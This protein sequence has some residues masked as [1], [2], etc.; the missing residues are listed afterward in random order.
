MIT[1]RVSL[2]VLQAGALRTIAEREDVRSAAEEFAGRPAV[3]RCPS[4]ASWSRCCG[5][6]TTVTSRRECARAAG[7]RAGGIRSDRRLAGGG[8]VHRAD[9]DRHPGRRRRAGRRAYGRRV[10]QEALTNVH[11]H[12]PGAH[13][14]VSIRYETAGI[15]VTV[16][17]TAAARPPDVDLGA[18]GTGLLALRSNASNSWARR[19]RAEP[20]DTGGFVVDA[21]SPIATPVTTDRTHPTH[22]DLHEGGRMIRTLLVDDERMVCAH[23]RTIL[24]AP[25]TSRSSARRTTAPRHWSRWSDTARRGPCSDLHMPGVDGLSALRRMVRLDTPPRVV[26]LTTI[27]TTTRVARAAHRRGRF[28]L[29][30]TRPE[31]LVALAAGGRGRQHGVVA[32]PPP[33]I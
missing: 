33:A 14:E 11:K 10:V 23:L 21:L 30:D 8:R 2:M 5:T 27:D 18:G 22:R 6:R 25:R 31:D 19:L 13:V 24:A 1:H 29:K 3:R 4:Y 12:A 16:A 15:G 9:R 32:R 28:L 26:V 20:D 7:D 17:N